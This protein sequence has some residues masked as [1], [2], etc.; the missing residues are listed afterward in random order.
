MQK[1]TMVYKSLNGFSAPEYLADLF[2]SRS[3]IT[4]YLPRDF[5]NKQDVPIPRTNFFEELL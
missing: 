2:D 4:E 5:V 3:D 1:A